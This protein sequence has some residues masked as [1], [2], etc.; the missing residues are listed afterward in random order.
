MERFLSFALRAFR[1]R[2][3]QKRCFMLIVQLIY[4]ND[5]LFIVPGELLA[6]F[7]TSRPSPGL[8]AIM[9]KRWRPPTGVRKQVPYDLLVYKRPH[10]SNEAL[11]ARVT[12]PNHR[13]D[14][15]A[16]RRRGAGC[17]SYSTV[18]Q[19][20]RPILIGR[21]RIEYRTSITTINVVGLGCHVLPNFSAISI[22]LFPRKNPMLLARYITSIT[23]FF[24]DRTLG[25]ILHLSLKR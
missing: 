4:S 21:G 9:Q 14:F 8:N 18:L 5:L 25:E 15:L 16:Q 20:P 3:S 2:Q 19:L 17:W 10:K 7:G 22:D 6:L 24:I 12:V 11:P 1:G 23:I 13:S